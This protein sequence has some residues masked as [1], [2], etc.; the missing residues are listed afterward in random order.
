MSFVSNGDI[1]LPFDTNRFEE[2]MPVNKIIVEDVSKSYPIEHG[3]KNRVLENINLAVR[4][5]EFLCLVGPSGCGKTTLINILAGFLS[6]DSGRV[7]I[8]GQ[9]ITRPNPKYVAVFQDYGLFPWRTVLK[10]IKFGLE[11]QKVPTEKQDE[12]ARSIIDLVQLTGFENRH[13]FE[14]SGG[15][16]QRVALARSLAVNPEIV[17]LD[18]PFNALDSVMRTKFQNDITT[19]WQQQQKTIILVTHDVEEAVYLS[20]RVA[21]MCPLPGRIKE[22][23]E[24]D[25]PRPRDRRDKA[26]HCLKHDVL[27]AMSE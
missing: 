3:E 26:F 12:I 16:K 4:E 17:F 20:D 13:P 9:T 1:S 27:K 8:D 19:I 22:V 24:V 7:L 14:L 25:L 11:I 6:P 18:E 23:I 10:N 5:K 15:M 2:T 21:V